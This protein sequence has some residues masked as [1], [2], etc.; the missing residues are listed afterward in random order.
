MR[1]A[2]HD[3]AGHPFQVQLSRELARRGHHILHLHFESFP[4]PKGGLSPRPGDSPTL[5]IEGIRFPD[6]FAKYGNFVRRRRQELRYGRIAAGR[7]AAFRPDAVISANTPLD[8]QRIIQRRTT[9]LGATFTF[10]LQDIYSEGIESCLRKSHFPGSALLG[11]WYRHLERSMLRA[12][13]AVVPIS[14]DFGPVLQRWGVDPARVHTVPNWAPLDELPVRPQENDWSREHGLA[15]K[16]VYLYSGTLGLKH[17]PRSLVEL[18]ES[19]HHRPEVAVVAISEG[20]GADWLR[21]Q[22]GRRKLSNFQVLPLQP[23]ER[24]PDV[25]GSASVLLALLDEAAAAYSVPSKVLTCLCAGRPLL[26]SVPASNLAA[27]I[28]WENSAGLVTQPGDLDAFLAAAER[29]YREPV[30]RELGARHGLEFARSAFDIGLIANRFENVMAHAAAA[31]HPILPA[32]NA[33]A[34]VRVL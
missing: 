20:C 10:W 32:G 23:W 27:E 14:R 11:A 5:R 22:I 1:I 31:A 25:L 33:P 2:V 34:A 13:D 9:R 4:T 15:G 16:F 26:V 8:A 24:M 17:D 28:V 6:G 29:L 7:I 18:A 19:M 3:Y 30:L 12:S 21:Q